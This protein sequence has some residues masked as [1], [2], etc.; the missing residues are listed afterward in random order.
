MKLRSYY[1][2]AIAL[3]LAALP[4]QAATYQ[5]FVLSNEGANGFITQLV[6]AGYG[7]YSLYDVMVELRIDTNPTVAGIITPAFINALQSLPASSAI[8]T[9]LLK[10]F[11]SGSQGLAIS[12]DGTVQVVNILGATYQGTPGTSTL[13]STVSGVGA[14][15]FVHSSTAGGTLTSFSAGGNTYNVFGIAFNSKIKVNQNQGTFVISNEAPGYLIAKLINAG[16]GGDSVYQATVY[17]ASMPGGGAIITPAF[18]NALAIAPAG[19]EIFTTTVAQ[20][21]ANGIS[22][23]I[24]T[25]GTARYD[26]IEAS[27]FVGPYPVIQ[28]GNGTVQNVRIVHSTDSAAPPNTTVIDGPL[29]G[30]TTSY[31]AF[32]VAYAV[33]DTPAATPVP[34]SLWLAV[35]GCLALFGFAVWA[36]RRGARQC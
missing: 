28:T 19:S 25:D 1:L 8:F 24:S 10:S 18:L 16:H 7:N 30:M 27:T 2:I 35:I 20:T 4:A 17:L 21:L 29:A 13:I 3:V 15:G 12:T 5:T 11:N 22:V 33:A 23:S 34:P 32:A 14:A 9:T 36:R 31:N 26:D 6:A